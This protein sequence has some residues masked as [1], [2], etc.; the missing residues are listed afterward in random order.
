[1]TSFGDSYS[2]L[3]K[4]INNQKLV[5]FTRL[6]KGNWD[7]LEIWICWYFA[8]DDA[9]EVIKSWDYEP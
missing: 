7:E 5:T 9:Q 3:N 8:G 1:M 4:T 6:N 2:A